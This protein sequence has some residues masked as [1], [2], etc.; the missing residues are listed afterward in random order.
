MITYLL[1]DDSV[2]RIEARKDIGDMIHAQI[3]DENSALIDVS[4][5]VVDILEDYENWEYQNVNYIFI[6]GKVC[7]FG[8]NAR[9][10]NIESGL[11][12]RFFIASNNSKALKGLFYCLPF[13]RLQ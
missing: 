1:D 11:N 4:G 8:N 9:K 6:T 12:G 7:R 3:Y 13:N 5:R 2:V 10:L